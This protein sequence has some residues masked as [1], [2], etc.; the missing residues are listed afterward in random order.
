VLTIKPHPANAIVAPIHP[1]AMPY[2]P[3]RIDRWLE[4]ETPNALSLQRPLAHDALRII[5]K[6]ERIDGHFV[7]DNALL[8]AKG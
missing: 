4:A 8:D 1:K 7:V 5:A 6:G 2:D 3:G